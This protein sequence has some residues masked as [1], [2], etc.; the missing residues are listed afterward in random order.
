[1][2]SPPTATSNCGKR[3]GRD[4]PSTRRFKW[5]IRADTA[6]GRTG[7]ESITATK[8]LC[9]SRKPTS[10][11]PL[12]A[13]V[14]TESRARDLYP[15]GEPAMGGKLISL[16]APNMP[17]CVLEHALFCRGLS[18]TIKMLHRAAPTGSEIWAARHYTLARCLDHRQGAGVFV[19]RLA[20][21]AGVFD[22]FTGQGALDE[23]RL[24]VHVRNAASVMIQRFNFRDW[25]LKSRSHKKGR[26]L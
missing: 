16:Q 17:E 22:G 26:R 9:R 8:L 1:M 20:P 4:M 6:G 21:V 13:T 15:Q 19:L 24:A 11:P 18:E 12:L 2:L 10:A 3:S 7:Q 5:G 25:H 14:R 23:D